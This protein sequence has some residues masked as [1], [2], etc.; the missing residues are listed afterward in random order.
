MELKQSIVIVSEF[1]VKNGPKSGSRGGSPGGYITRYLARSDAHDICTPVNL[2]DLNDYTL[3]Y[4]ARD[5]AT[6][7]ILERDEMKKKTR[8]TKKFD[9]IAFGMRNGQ[10]HTSLSDKTYRDYAKDIQKCFDNGK[11]VI[12]TVVS[13]DTEYL[14]E[15]GVIA[16]DFE[17]YERGDFRGNIDQMKLRMSVIQGLDRM[18]SCYDNLCYVGVIQVDTANVHCH[19]AMVD[20]GVGAKALIYKR[21]EHGIVTMTRTNEQKGKLPQKAIDRLRRGIDA[22]LD[23]NRTVAFMKSSVDNYRKNVKMYVQ[24]TMWRNDELVQ[25]LLA[26]LPRNSYHWGANTNNPKMKKANEIAKMYVKFCLA[27]PE[28]G[29][30]KVRSSIR[31]YADFRRD[32]EGLNLDKHTKLINNGENQVMNDCINGIYSNLKIIRKNRDIE[33]DYENDDVNMFVYNLR[34]YNSRILH[35]SVSRDKACKFIKDY[36]TAMAVGENVTESCPVYEFFKFEEEYQEKIFNKYQHLLTFQPTEKDNNIPIKRRKIKHKF[37]DIKVLDLHH[38]GYDYATDI[39]ISK[40]NL[41]AYLQITS[42]RAAL[43][44]Q[45]KLHLKSMEDYET[46]EILPIRD[47]ALMENTAKRLVMQE[48]PILPSL[49]KKAVVLDK[50]VPIIND[51]YEDV[52]DMMEDLYAPAADVV[53]DIFSDGNFSEEENDLQKA[54][55]EL[56][57]ERE[58]PNPPK[59]LAKPKS[60]VEQPAFDLKSTP[61]SKTLSAVTQE[62][63]MPI[64]ELATEPEFASAPVSLLKLSFEEKAAAAARRSKAHEETITTPTPSLPN[65]VP[66]TNKKDK[67]FQFGDD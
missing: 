24:G 10:K 21:D 3:R 61:K 22:F 8:K 57:E 29:Y 32:R 18:S 4:M 49:R 46:L 47:V 58:N 26:S 43:L 51:K 20:K 55:A 38:M 54:L 37:Q 41:E 15:M 53:H 66:I 16:K 17:F 6:E 63:S 67:D 50:A 23:E 27:Q 13:F 42:H 36:E 19:L 9:G 14:R 39:K 33:N 31:D 60:V 65:S 44:E 25:S 62:S 12:K 52:Y 2:H 35:A 30:H 40:E 45:A 48:Q 5:S 1:T 56:T 11:T 28:S 34:N 59:S 64:P 7:S